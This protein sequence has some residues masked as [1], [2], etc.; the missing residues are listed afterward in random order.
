MQAVLDWFALLVETFLG[1]LF[2]LVLWAP[3]KIFELFTDG[4]A[5]IVDSLPF[6]DWLGS[7]GNLWGGLSCSVGYFLIPFNIGYGM[8]IISSAYLIRFLIRRLPLVG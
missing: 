2:E 7:V 4:L 3:R 5:A 1:W 8:T 6:P